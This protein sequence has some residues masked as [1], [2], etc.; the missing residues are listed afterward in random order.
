MRYGKKG[1]LIHSHIEPEALLTLMSI[2][3]RRLKSVHGYQNRKDC[4]KSE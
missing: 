3:R 4:T 1:F 2:M